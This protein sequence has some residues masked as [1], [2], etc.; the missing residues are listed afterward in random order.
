LPQR[1]LEPLHTWHRLDPSLFGAANASWPSGSGSK[2]CISSRSTAT[3]VF[4]RFPGGLKMRPCHELPQGRDRG[5]PIPSAAVRH[6][7][8]LHGLILVPVEPKGHHRPPG[9]SSQ[10]GGGDEGRPTAIGEPVDPLL[11]SSLHPQAGLAVPKVHPEPLKVLVHELK[12]VT[13]RKNIG[14]PMANLLYG[15]G[16]PNRVSALF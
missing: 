11:P 7:W 4:D 3:T 5:A 15:V 9:G 12:S 2:P 1:F 14:A 10:A 6:L 16:V 13:E 8:H